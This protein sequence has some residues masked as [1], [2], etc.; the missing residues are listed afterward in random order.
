MVCIEQFRQTACR[1]YDDVKNIGIPLL[2]CDLINLSAVNYYS[3]KT[4]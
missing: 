1:S 3:Q 2:H 4:Y